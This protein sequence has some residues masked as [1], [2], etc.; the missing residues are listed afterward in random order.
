MPRQLRIEYAG[1][2]YHVMARGDRREE[3]VW[4]DQDCVAFEK[5]WEEVVVGVS[6]RIHGRLW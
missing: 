2:V 5:L 3:I 4:D 1:A 6:P